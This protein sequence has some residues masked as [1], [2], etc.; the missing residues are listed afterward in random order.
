MSASSIF[1]MGR[2]EYM[3]RYMRQRR[4]RLRVSK[5][6]D[7]QTLW[8][9]QKCGE[10]FVP[11]DFPPKGRGR[12]YTCKACSGRRVEVEEY[13]EKQELEAFLRSDEKA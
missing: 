7:G 6:V 10:W 9:C 11:E 13:E 1:D 8:K 5:E 3:R 2:K 12:L 4:K